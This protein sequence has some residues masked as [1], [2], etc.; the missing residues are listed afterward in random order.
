[1]MNGPKKDERAGQRLADQLCVVANEYNETRD[2]E[3]KKL[4]E[5]EVKKYY[6]R[7]E[8]LARKVAATGKYTLSFDLPGDRDDGP[9][10][11]VVNALLQRLGAESLS[12]EPPCVEGRVLR[13]WICWGPPFPGARRPPPGPVVPGTISGT[14]PAPP[15]PPPRKVSC[16]CGAPSCFD[17]HSGEGI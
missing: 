7:V 8:S 13:I 14:Q 1:M 17:C 11:A 5:A 6:E 16:A 12:Y 10:E 4:L 15:A 3:R 9:T 2:H